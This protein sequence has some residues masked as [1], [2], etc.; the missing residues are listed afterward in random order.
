MFQDPYNYNCRHFNSYRP[1]APRYVCKGC[2][3]DEEFDRTILLINLDAMG[4]V[5]AAS[6][7]P[8]PGSF[9]SIAAIPLPTGSGAFKMTAMLLPSVKLA[10]EEVRRY[11]VRME[12]ARLALAALRFRAARGRLPETLAE[13]VPDFVEGMLVDPYDGKPLRPE[14]GTKAKVFY[15]RSYSPERRT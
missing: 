3:E 5:V 10:V 12:S 14:L 2:T 7:R 6:R 1:C 15:I 13:L 11:V 4:D 9:R 8:Y